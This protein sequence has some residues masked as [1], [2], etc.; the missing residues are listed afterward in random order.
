MIVKSGE[1]KEDIK[2]NLRGG[3]GNAI[4]NMIHQTNDFKNV[5]MMTTITLKPG[6]SIGVHEHIEETE[7]YYILEGK[8]LVKESSGEITVEKGDT[9]ITTDKQSHCIDN[10][11][12]SDL[13]F[14]AIIVTF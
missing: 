13:V 6:C 10:I 1:C 5:K 4:L 3:N 8:G 12:D 9:V 11:G 7:Y 14:L 2:E